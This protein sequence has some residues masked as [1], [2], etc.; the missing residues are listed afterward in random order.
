MYTIVDVGYECVIVNEH[1]LLV[2]KVI[3]YRGLHTLSIMKEKFI[4][5]WFLM[6][7]DFLLALHLC[8]YWDRIDII[9]HN[10]NNKHSNYCNEITYF[11]A[12]DFGD[13]LTVYLCVFSILIL[14]ICALIN[15]Y[16]K[17]RME[18]LEDA[19]R[20]YNSL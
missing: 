14:S 19:I 18:M 11:T 10:P 3:V 1:S 2:P 12:G 13:G 15:N 4:K 6:V 5:L 20:V 9:G 16:C 8:I 17:I 7:I